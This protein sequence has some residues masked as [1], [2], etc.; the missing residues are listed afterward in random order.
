VFND[1]NGFTL[2]E[3]IISIMVIAVLGYISGMV[4]LEISEKYLYAKQNTSVAQQGQMA[5]TRLKKEFGSIKSISSGTPTTI[6]YTST[7]DVSEN[8]SVCWAGGSSPVVI[9]RNAVDCSDSSISGD[10]L[11]YNVTRFNLTY[12]NTYTDCSATFPNNPN[13]TAA[14]ILIIEVKLSI[15][16][17]FKLRSSDS[18]T[19]NIADPDRVVLGLESG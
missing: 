13:Y 6:T 16:K 1:A 2:I 7:R 4:L 18:A 15:D 3:I 9:K 5:I 19:I 14:S 8:I 10:I 11:A 12:C 17:K